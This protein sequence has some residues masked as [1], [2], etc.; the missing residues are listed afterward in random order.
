MSARFYDDTR[1]PFTDAQQVAFDNANALHFAAGQLLLEN[2][3]KLA[4]MLYEAAAQHAP[5]P[6]GKI[7]L[8]AMAAE[9]LFTLR[10]QRMVH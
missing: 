4:A 9:L 7:A 6:E 10:A 1:K 5:T 2:R 3:P 8:L